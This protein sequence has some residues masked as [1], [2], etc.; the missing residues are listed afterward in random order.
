MA[1]HSPRMESEQA[2]E[3]VTPNREGNRRK[4][5][6]RTGPRRIGDRGRNW[7]GR[8]EY[9]QWKDRERWRLEGD[10]RRASKDRRQAERRGEQGDRRKGTPDRRALL[11]PRPH[12]STDCDHR[13]HNDDL[14]VRS[15]GHDRSATLA[16]LED[17]VDE[18]GSHGSTMY[19]PGACLN[20]QASQS[21]A[22]PS[23]NLFQ[24]LR[25][26]SERMRDRFLRLFR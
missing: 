15:E 18:Q 6:Q 13:L 20:A 3:G 5:E 11:N 14:S 1:E 26:V 25:E 22:A 24:R 9:K 16:S 8:I 19:S 7:R 21:Q 2:T 17:S 23:G 10:R 12:R 4:A